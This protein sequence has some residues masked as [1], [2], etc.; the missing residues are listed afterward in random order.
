MTQLVQRNTALHPYHPISVYVKRILKAALY[1]YI[2][3][4]PSHI[5]FKPAVHEIQLLRAT[6]FCTVETNA[7][8]HSVCNIIYVTVLAPRNLIWF[9]DFSKIYKPLI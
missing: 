7:C 5:I 4:H 3:A 9:L 1:V 2:N 6:K 8:E